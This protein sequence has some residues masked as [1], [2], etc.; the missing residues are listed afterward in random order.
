MAGALLV[1]LVAGV[2]VVVVYLACLRLFQ[3]EELEWLLRRGP[4]ARRR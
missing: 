2:A 1:C 3:V 4:L